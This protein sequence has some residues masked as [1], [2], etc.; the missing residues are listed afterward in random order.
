[1]IPTFFLRMELALQVVG[2]KMT[3]QIEDAKNVAMRIVGSTSSD[4]SES[5]NN[6]P[7]MIHISPPSIRDLRALLVAQ[8]G[9]ID[10]FESRIIDF[11]SIL[12]MPLGGSAPHSLSTSKAVSCPSSSGQTLLH[13]SASLGLVSLTHFLIEHGADLDVRDCNG[14]TPLHFA[15]LFQSHGCAAA[16]INVGAD[17]EIVDSRGKT[18]E[19][20]SPSGVIQNILAKQEEAQSEDGW[21]DED[22][23]LGD[24]E[25]DSDSE[26]RRILERRIFTKTSRHNQ[27]AKGTP[28][29]SANVSRAATPPPAIS[30]GE[31]G[32]K[33]D[34]DKQPIS[35]VTDAKRAASFMEK[36]RTF[37]QI[38]S[39]PG[40][41]PNI[42]QLPLPHFSAVPWATLPQ[43]PIVFP[44]FVPTNWASLRGG[45]NSP[46]TGSR[47]DSE[48]DEATKNVGNIALRTAH[49]WRATW[50]KWVALAVAT[51]A[52]QQ[53]DDIPPPVYTPRAEEETQVVP[54]STVEAPEQPVTSTSRRLHPD[55]RPVGYDSTPIPDQVVESFAYQPNTK[56]SR[57]LRKKRRLYL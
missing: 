19:E 22:G 56:Q 21:E 42:P 36:M 39:R 16:L 29:W 13:L 43:I 32:K 6:A 27:S 57:K 10:N 8:A 48:G 7:G 11:L 52:R 5:N 44:V 40:I 30:S 50:E 41:I 4:S 28:H 54:Q 31:K 38:P 47:S 15:A 14:F 12:D 45:P 24:A 18:P 20:I 2:L 9:E 33:T 55:T 53:A 23:D 37:A 46:T 17:L 26:L 51:T 35:D 49:E 34:L 1:M 3:G 25:E